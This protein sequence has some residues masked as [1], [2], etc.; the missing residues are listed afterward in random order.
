[1]TSQPKR[2]IDESNEIMSAILSELNYLIDSDE[3]K[4][5]V[6]KRLALMHANAMLNS[7]PMTYAYPFYSQYW[8]DVIDHIASH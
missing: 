6:A 5:R 4:V 1:M 3:Y 8:L 2:P 7:V